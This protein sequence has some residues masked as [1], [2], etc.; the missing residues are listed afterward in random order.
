[1][2]EEAAAQVENTAAAGAA[3]QKATKA[4]VVQ[5]MADKAE[6]S[7]QANAQKNVDLMRRV[8]AGPKSKRLKGKA[9]AEA[10]PSTG[11]GILGGGTKVPR[12]W[13]VSFIYLFIYLI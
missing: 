5:C 12:T 4:A 11:P 6:V 1:M 7:Q 9:S 10:G 3:A 13:E 8:H 2:T